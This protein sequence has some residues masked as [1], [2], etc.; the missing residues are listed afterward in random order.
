MSGRQFLHLHFRLDHQV[1]EMLLSAADQGSALHPLSCD[2]AQ[3]GRKGRHERREDLLVLDGHLGRPNAG[4][5]RQQR[6]EAQQRQQAGHR[7]GAV[8]LL[9]Q[10]LQGCICE[11]AVSLALTGK[12]ICMLPE[13]AN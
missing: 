1:G 10:Q 3:D 8:E 5:L 6:R 4:Q 9:S 13:P 7:M 12:G 2:Y 11:D